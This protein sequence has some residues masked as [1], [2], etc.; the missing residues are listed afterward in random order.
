M[1]EREREREINDACANEQQLGPYMLT[2]VEL[3]SFD[4]HLSPN[5]CTI[6]ERV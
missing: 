5:H 1:S 3:R 4:S 2:T 6:N